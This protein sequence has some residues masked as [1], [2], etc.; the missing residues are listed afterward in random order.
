M[1]TSPEESTTGFVDYYALLGVAPPAT[2]SEIE[3]AY[4][5]T[6]RKY[7]P[8][9]HPADK[10]FEATAAF[11]PYR[12]AFDTL[13]NYASRQRYHRTYFYKFAWDFHHSTPV[14][15]VL[16]QTPNPFW[17]IM[18]QA[19]DGTNDELLHPN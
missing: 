3:K 9:N 13:T 16:F 2:L 5:S 19:N 14:T 18:L 12:D 10:F 11:T 8:K 17:R 4:Y 15:N 7:H 1:S 6:E